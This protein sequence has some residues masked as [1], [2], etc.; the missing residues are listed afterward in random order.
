M[1]HRHDEAG[2]VLA[3]FD[4]VQRTDIDVLGIGRARMHADPAIDDNA[5]IGLAHQL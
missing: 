4:A 2:V 1:A 5:G 3:D